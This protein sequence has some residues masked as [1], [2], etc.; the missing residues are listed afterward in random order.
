[1]N[2]EAKKR[3][4]T[5]RK[6][7]KAAPKTVVVA[8]VQ[9]NSEVKQ[10]T[11]PLGKRT[12]LHKQK[13][14]GIKA[15]PGF[16]ARQVVEKPGRVEK[17]LEAGYVFCEGQERLDTDKRIQTANGLGDVCRQVVNFH[18]LGVGEA[19]TAVW[20]E[21]PI[22]YYEEDQ[23]E[24]L[25]RAQEQENLINPEKMQAEQPDVYYTST[26]KKSLDD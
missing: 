11:K 20:M 23:R 17:F 4:V 14:V 18:N 22:E 24:K 15:R 10:V 25:R 21:I 12:P 8:E 5:T 19:S 26:F 16:V 13:S 7:T 2:E 9:E 1:M 3:K 6:N